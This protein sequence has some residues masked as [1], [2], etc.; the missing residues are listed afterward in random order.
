MNRCIVLGQIQGKEGGYSQTLLLKRRAALMDMRGINQNEI[1][2]CISRVNDRKQIHTANQNVRAMSKT[3]A[4][5]NL[6]YSKLP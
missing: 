4:M 5:S 2:M 6:I 3:E 1:I